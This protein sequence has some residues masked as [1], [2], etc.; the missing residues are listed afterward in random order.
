MHTALIDTHGED[1]L[2]DKNKEIVNKAILEQ[3]EALISFLSRHNVADE[4]EA[5]HENLSN[6]GQYAYSDLGFDLQKTVSQRSFLSKALDIA[7]YGS[8]TLFGKYFSMLS[9]RTALDPWVSDLAERPMTNSETFW[10]NQTSPITNSSEAASVNQTSPMTNSSETV[11]VN[12]TSPM[13]NSS[14]AVSVNQTSSVSNVSTYQLNSRGHAF[15]PESETANIGATA[16]QLML[17]FLL[18]MISS[19]LYCGL[20]DKRKVQHESKKIITIVA[21]SI[22]QSLQALRL[23][24]GAKDLS[25]AKE[26]AIKTASNEIIAEFE[27]NTGIIIRPR[28]QASPI[29]ANDIDGEGDKRPFYKGF[30]DKYKQAIEPLYYCPKTYELVQSTVSEL[31]APYFSENAAHN[32]N[33]T[34]PNLDDPMRYLD[35]EG[36][37]NTDDEKGDQVLSDLTDMFAPAHRRALFSGSIKM[38]QSWANRLLKM[39]IRSGLIHL[40][41]DPMIIKATTE[42]SAERSWSGEIVNE[43]RTSSTPFMPEPVVVNRDIDT[44]Y[45]EL[46][47]AWAVKTVGSALAMFGGIYIVGHLMKAY[48]SHQRLQEI[49]TLSI[50]DGEMA[51]QIKEHVNDSG[52]VS[53]S[54]SNLGLSEH[55]VRSVLSDDSNMTHK[56]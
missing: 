43:S 39:V 23:Q 12:Q 27:N 28:S 17:H 21:N 20:A 30:V 48:N 36:S 3:R 29:S 46:G 4:E 53:I 50:Q 51:K 6:S 13:T 10:V 54:P 5:S 55:S 56:V 1:A 2:S 41:M 33:L 7:A 35:D 32:L 19:T 15:F 31:V 22:N 52:E 16:E 37:P 45:I 18:N 40:T 42:T 14:E 49:L 44:I 38:A 34:E 11:A 26:S 25:A 47:K 24:E 9:R 8:N